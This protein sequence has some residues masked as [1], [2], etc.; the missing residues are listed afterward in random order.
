MRLAGDDPP[1]RK[2][3]RFGVSTESLIKL[4]VRQAVGVKGRL[5]DPALHEGIRQH[6]QAVETTVFFDAP[7]SP[8]TSEVKNCFGNTSRIENA[9]WERKIALRI[10]FGLLT[11]KKGHC[12]ASTV[13][14]RTHRLSIFP[15]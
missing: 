11:M 1:A 6:V 5:P 10:H 12:R 7:A 2:H 4:T 15:T 14:L 3:R 13:T 8:N 9:V